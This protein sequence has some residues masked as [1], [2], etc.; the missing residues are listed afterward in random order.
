M[1]ASNFRILLVFAFL[2]I[3]SVI[4][5]GQT[6][7]LPPNLRRTTSNP[8]QEAYRQVQ[9]QRTMES[10]QRVAMRRAEEEARSSATLPQGPRIEISAKDRKR[11]AL[12]LKPNPEDLVRYKD[13]LNQ[14]RTGIFRLFPN[15]K[16]D[17]YR[18]IRVDGECANFVPGG[19]NYSFRTNSMTPDIHFLDGNFLAK[20]F[21]S[22]QIISRVGDI[23][24]DSITM[25]SNEAAFLRDFTPET[26]FIDAQ[27]Q[28]KKI[29]K[30]IKANGFEYSNLAAIKL[31]ESYVLRIVA[32]RNRNN[33]ERRMS[34]DGL[35]VDD[36]KLNFSR[37]QTD[38]RIDVT[39]AF[40]VVRQDADGNVTIIWKELSRQ[41]AP[42]I[43]FDDEQEMVDFS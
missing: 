10:Q 16:C 43:V 9:I 7:N 1:K 21:F 29:A 18:V 8:D 23:P 38:N 5:F 36:P 27:A 2:T 35:I 33:I 17:E 12:L 31:N 26:T 32:F 6:Q 22:L 37:I 24:L 13:F 14:D 34:R 19:S 41:K 3:L 20:G 15:S 25:A 40:R 42:V 28:I 11:I 4:A 39:I 30:V